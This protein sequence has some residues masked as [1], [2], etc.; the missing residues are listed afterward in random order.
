MGSRWFQ[1]TEEMPTEKGY[2][3][4]HRI[5]LTVGETTA[6]KGDS[7][8]FLQTYKSVNYLQTQM[9]ITICRHKGYKEQTTRVGLIKCSQ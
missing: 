9:G 3:E 7:I 4:S 5:N 1:S 2:L 8:V 6:N